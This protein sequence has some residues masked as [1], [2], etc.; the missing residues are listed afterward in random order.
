[1]DELVDAIVTPPPANAP[2]YVRGHRE[3]HLGERPY[4]PLHP[5]MAPMMLVAVDGNCGAVYFRDVD[6]DGHPIGFVARGDGRA[7]APRLPFDSQGGIEFEPPDVMNR[8]QLRRVVRSYL[9]DGKQPEV[10]GWRE[11][12]W[13]Q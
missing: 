2:L 3:I 9:L 10:V 12:E 6:A 4:D 7:D 8:D 1:M 13:V 5:E 11:S